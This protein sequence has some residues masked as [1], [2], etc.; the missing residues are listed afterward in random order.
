MQANLAIS[1]ANVGIGIG[2]A[3]DIICGD[4]P[5]APAWL[6]DRGFEWFCRM[7]Y[8]PKRLGRRYLIEDSPFV[9]HLAREIFRQRNA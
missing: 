6:K 1:G 8:E 3:F 9:F 2:S 7:L 4:T 5:R